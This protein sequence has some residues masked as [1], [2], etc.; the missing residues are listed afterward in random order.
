MAGM[1]TAQV[2]DMAPSKKNTATTGTRPP[3]NLGASSTGACSDSPD[4]DTAAPHRSSRFDGNR[5]VGDDHV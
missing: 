1:R 3:P 2:A 4:L 5:T